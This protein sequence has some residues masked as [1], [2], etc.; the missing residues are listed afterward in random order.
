MTELVTRL[1]WKLDGFKKKPFPIF[2]ADFVE[3]AQDYIKIKS[4]NDDLIT[5]LERFNPLTEITSEDY[6]VRSL[7]LSKAKAQ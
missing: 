7:A 4:I 2:W 5:A 1:Q 6:R 3:A